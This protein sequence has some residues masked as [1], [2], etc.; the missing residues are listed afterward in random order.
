MTEKIKL[1][2]VHQKISYL[3][4]LF[5]MTIGVGVCVGLFFIGSAYADGISSVVLSDVDSTGYGLDGRDFQITW[6]PSSTVPVGYQMTQIFITTSGVQLATDTLFS[7][8][9]GGSACQP[10]GGMNQFSVG[11][12]TLPQS[13]KEDSTRTSLATSSS[14]IAW[15][16]VQ[17]DEPFL[18]SSTPVSYADAFD[19]VADTNAPQIMHMSAHATTESADATVYAMVFDDQ[20]TAEQFSDAGDGGVEYFKLYYKTDAEVWDSANSST[21]SLVVDAGE[22]YSFVVPTSSVPTAGGTVSYYLVAQDRATPTPNMRYFC[23]SPNASS[24]GDCQTSPFVMNSVVAGSRTVSGKVTSNG[25]NVVG[26]TVF[27]GGYAKT[28]V[29]TDPGGDYIITGLP[30]NDVFDFSATKMGYA[31][32]QRTET[33]GTS[34]KTGVNID[35][36]YG[37]MGFFD[38]GD[39][40]GDSMGGAPHV[41][42]SGPPEGM[43]GFPLDENLRVGFSQPLDSTT[44]NTASSATSSNIYIIKTMTGQNVAGTVTYCANNIQTGCSS[45]FSM[46]NNVVLFDPSSDLSTST[47]Y[48]LVITGK[49]K[50]QGGQAIQGNRPE[51]GHKINFSSMGSQIGDFGA[52]FTGGANGLG[53]YGNGGMYMPPFTRSMSPAPGMSVAPNTNI[54]L[55]F[56]QAMSVSTIINTNI[57][58]WTGA[59]AQVTD[60]NVSVSLD[61]NEQR[62][63]TMSHDAL[64]AGEYEVRVKGAVANVSGL[65]MRGDNNGDNVAF[66]SRFNVSG[67]ND[68]TAP[69]IYPSLS[70]NATGVPTNKIFEFGFNEQLAFSTVNSSNILMYQ[71]ATAQTIIVNYDPGKNSV[72]VASPSA[73]T[74][75]TAYSITFNSGVTDLADNGIATTT[76]TYTTGAMDTEAPKLIEARCDDYRCYMRFSEPMNRDSFSDSKWASSTIN[77]DNW[78]LTSEGVV[79]FTGK[80]INYDSIDNSITIEGLLLSLGVDYTITAN[81]GIIDMSENLISGSDR[82]FAGKVENSKETYGN[83]GGAS[84]FGPP[85]ENM[86]GNG[87]I[88]QGEFKPQGFGD[89]TADQFAMGQADMAYP[90]NPL[91]S[92]DVNVFQTRFT[93]GVVLATGDQVVLT[94]PNGTTVT[95]V[96]FDTQSPFYTD[97]NQFMTGVVTGTAISA[98]NA[99]GKVTITLGVSGTP[100]IS[101]QITIDL[102]K[103]TNPSIP[104]GPQTGGYTLGMKVIRSGAVLA[105]KTSMPYFIMAGGTNTLT[106]DVAAG[107]NTST[108][109]LGAD[110]TVYLHGGGPGGPMDKVLTFVDGDIFEVDGTAGTSIVYNNLPDGCYFVGTD[111]YISLGGNDYYGQMSPEPVCL[112]SGESQ[113]KWFLLSPA[114]AGTTATVTIKFV[115]G[116]GDPYNFGGKDIDIFAGGPGKSVVKTLTGVTTASVGGYQIKLNDNG[117]WYVGMGPAMPKGASSGKPASLGV[118]PPPPMQ[119]KVSNIATTPAVSLGMG[120]APPGVAFD[121]DTDTITFTFA[122]A[123][124]TVTGTVKDGS[125]TGLANVEVF[126]NRQG[127]GA[128]VFTETDASGVFSL[129]VTDYGN[130]EIGAHKDG[131][132]EAHKSIDVRNES[133]TKLY[134]DGKNVTGAFNLTMKKPSYTISGKVLDNTNNGIGYAPIVATDAGGNTVFSGTS[135]DGSYTLFVDNGTWTVRAE[136]PP[137]KTDSCGGFS[138]TVV[139]SSA[140]MASQ[141]I[142][143]TVSTCYTLSGTVS[144]GGTNL[145]N[146]PLFI[147]EWDAVNDRPVAA[148]VKRGTGTDSNGQYSTKVG[149]GTYRIGTLH[150][151]YGELSS[152]STVAGNTTKNITVATTANVTFSFTGGTSDMNAFIELKNSSDKN[153]RV[154]KQVNSLAT[155]A[156]LTGQDG[157]TYN[158]F[159]DV[160]GI[161][162]FTGTVIAGGDT[163][164]IDLGVSSGFVTVTGTIYDGSDNA[165]AGALVMFSNASTTVTAVTDESGQYSIQIKAGDYDVSDSLAGFV[166]ARGTNVSFTTS[167]AAYDFGGASPDQS[168][169]QATPYTIEGT[170]YASDGSTPMTDGYVW[171]S[172]ASST[173]VS[174]PVD[175]NTG[176]YS[177]PVNNGVWII[178]AVGPLHAKTTRSGTVTVSGASQTGKDI[179]LTSET[180]NSVTSTSGI[181]SARTGGSVNDASGSGIKLTAAG[182]VLE[183]GSGNV[184]LNFEKNYTAPDTKNFQALGNATFGISAS[185]NSTIKNLTGNAEIQLDYFSLLADLP[186]NV[187]ESDLQLAYYSPER[188]EY[189]PVEGGFTI[190]ADNNTITGLVNHFTD[191][192]ITYRNGD[193]GVT[194]TESDSS[195][196]VTEGGATDS[197]TYVLTSAP[198][199]NV[200]ITPSASG[201]QVSLSPTSM[202][203]TTVNWATPQTLTVT[204]VNDSS[205]EGTHSGTITHEITSDDANYAGVSISNITATITDNDSAGG[206]GGG[207]GGVDITPPTDTSIVIANN[208]TSTTSTTVN[209]AL[210]AVGAS[211]MMIGND[212]LFTS[213]TWE[214]Y[215]TT[216][217]WVLTSATGTK[218]VYTKFR[219]T[220]GNI[221]SVV[222]DTIELLAGDVTTTPPVVEPKQEEKTEPKNIACS[223]TIGGAYKLSTNSAVYY[224]TSDCTK[225][226]FTHAD[227]FFTYFSSWNDV[228]VTAEAMLKTIPNDTLSFMPRGPKYDPKYGA[229]VKIVTDPKVYLL[230]GTEKYWITS[231]D[232]FEALGY[233]WNWIEDID[234]S[235]LNKYTLGS[236]IGYLN[237]HPNYTLI[238]YKNDPKV[239]RLEPDPKDASKQVRRH[240]KDAPT[241]ESLG[242]RWDR[243]VTVSDAEIY[244]NGNVLAVGDT[245]KNETQPTAGNTYAFDIDLSS[246][247]SG[248]AVIKLQKK[249]KELNFFKYPTITGYYGLATVEAVQA[250]QKVYGIST[251][252]IVGPQ[253]RAKLNS[254]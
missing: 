38:G 155:D 151:D 49:V 213:S 156:V 236:E 55:E 224:I 181:V 187:S 206:G 97:F 53:D 96:A 199:T 77:L 176:A 232:V 146:V 121:T 169:L 105:N 150:P 20:T 110:G 124:V 51:G 33:I 229:L 68:L 119:L 143:P 200:V 167:T 94:F 197:I 147:E 254:L 240:I 231:P 12:T 179:T 165:K 52:M 217:T 170:V 242:F 131:M 168:A 117:F 44:V 15:I 13:M 172:N 67:A 65:L 76:Y 34:N 58:L 73:L 175:P 243:I 210:G 103:I 208:A 235:L 3:L 162:K 237:H 26:A 173:M 79:D 43:Q 161:G 57:T 56:D 112:D 10:W 246:G 2:F 90:F 248:G 116:A 85:T 102:R 193:A 11:T 14:Y 186:E 218:M 61:S 166:P 227:I 21:A 122:S 128:P 66:S 203:F 130:Y 188:D 153:K 196:A 134:V 194:V 36:N 127:F 205:V 145:S 125:G 18:V 99:T 163:K 101:D 30:N 133:G 120:S 148:G 244:A 37:S 174:T 78:T 84:M 139:V 25:Q 92:N 228:H 88:G 216:K 180:G 225:R 60:K 214:V 89:F 251:L 16:Y 75:N 202:T 177:L 63:V 54:L 59:G 160:F 233:S 86:M 69:T 152:T 41:V 241:F 204:A 62:F 48:T 212:S 238:K 4:M 106:V 1:H 182:G 35:I 50:S 87:N 23:A 129:S 70:N 252:G 9:C 192:V 149:V 22:L 171:G 72:F 109:T 220:A 190:D 185:G 211:H 123:N 184:T 239:Y 6:A 95:N 215:T 201:S 136:L 28:A 226:I 39:S 157:V 183:S 223:L 74:P 159:V 249:L 80:S 31:S 142:T 135:A 46:D 219:D 17:A 207:G 91:V 64:S 107:S 47:Q 114:S 144:V 108:P 158:Y 247:M 45:L 27:V 100:N 245:T 253:T 126:M 104:K 32:S 191:F 164:T 189:V 198:T 29:L 132:P 98:D 111:P 7:T 138:K 221:S 178:K 113:T 42:F 140:S 81:A 118:M 250:F 154:S 19:D 115:D 137:D 83:F 195:T 5:F 8:G 93:P 222:S 24:V 40:G 230:L 71:G 141:N 209:L 82:S 234:V